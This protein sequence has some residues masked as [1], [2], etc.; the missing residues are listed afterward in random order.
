MVAIVFVA[1]PAPAVAVEASPIAVAIT[2]LIAVRDRFPTAAMELVPE[3]L[4]IAELSIS[5][6]ARAASLVVSICE[7]K[8]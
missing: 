8:P 3:I 6:I 1:I 4:A 2:L 7:L 5:K